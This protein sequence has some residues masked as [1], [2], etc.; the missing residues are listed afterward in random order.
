MVASGH[1]VGTRLGVDRDVPASNGAALRLAS[2]RPPY[3]RMC[4]RHH[5]QQHAVWRCALCRTRVV[6]AIAGA[7]PTATAAGIACR[8]AL[9]MH[10]QKI[11]LMPLSMQ[12]RLQDGPEFPE[13]V[14]RQLLDNDDVPLGENLSGGVLLVAFEGVGGNTP[15]P[16]RF[17]DR[18]LPRQ[19][20]QTS[21]R[22][23]S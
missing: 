8:R 4:G 16:R 2:A 11:D 18:R 20:S 12:V 10:L 6:G 5:L 9:A 14:R 3:R 21:T 22:F 1:P 17:K 13:V 19:K 23:V 15:A 7:M